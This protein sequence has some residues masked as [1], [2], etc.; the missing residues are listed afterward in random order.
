MNYYKKKKKVASENPERQLFRLSA[1]DWGVKI[2]I[3]REYVLK[4]LFN[5]LKINFY[6]Q[7]SIV[8]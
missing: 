1:L 6:Q 4:Y 2:K 7:F 5:N 8:L 3:T